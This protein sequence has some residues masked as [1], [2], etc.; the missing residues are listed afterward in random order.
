MIWI[1]I[2]LIIVGTAAFLYCLCKISAWAD[3]DMEEQN[4]D[5]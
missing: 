4:A 5:E 3:E 2:T 1:P